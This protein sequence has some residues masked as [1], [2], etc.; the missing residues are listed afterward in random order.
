MIQA[1]VSAQ[2]LRDA[3]IPALS[4]LPERMTSKEAM[5]MLVAIG[6]QESSLTQRRQ[7]GGPARGLWQFEAAGGVKGVLEHKATKHI[8]AFVCASRSVNPDKLAVHAQLAHDDILAAAFARMLLWTLPGE[9]SG[10][11]DSGTGW[12]QYLD[13]W[14]PGKP[15]PTAWGAYYKT[16]WE[17]V[18]RYA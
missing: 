11:D 1:S 7:V 10:K 9:L 16:A 13:A 3:I 4:I 8:A 15:R 17:V 6:L 2:I 18:E 14:R 5:A 12:K